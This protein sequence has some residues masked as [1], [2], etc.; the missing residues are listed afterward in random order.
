[1]AIYVDQAGR[2]IDLSNV[3][4]RIISIV[5]SQTELLFD[6]GLDDEVVGITKFCVHP[7]E[8]FRSKMR[9][10][11]TKQ[12]NLDLIHSLQPDLII[13]NR[14]ENEKAQVEELEKFYPVWVSDVHTIGDACSMMR[15][16][17]SMTGKTKEAEQLIREI[18]DSFQNYTPLKPK[19]KTLYLIW[20]KPYMTVGN[21]TFIHEMMERAGFENVFSDEKRYPEITFSQ[22]QHLDFDLLLLSSEPFPFKEKHKHEFEIQLPGVQ[23]EL[24]D[25]EIFSW[26]GSRL[27]FAASYF[28]SLTGHL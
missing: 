13:A 21:D 24:V 2:N 16:I 27:K 18:N 15:S 10:G 20:Q 11:G 17:G 19:R 9:V 26:Y 3:P 22:I 8:W 5:P 1:M 28:N 14:E 4:K 12:V 6:L 25:G 23:V 7:N